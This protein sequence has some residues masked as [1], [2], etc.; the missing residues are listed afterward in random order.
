M[1][2]KGVEAVFIL[3]TAGADGVERTAHV[4][5]VAGAHQVQRTQRNLLAADPQGAEA[6]GG[7]QF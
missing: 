5:A 6:V 2:D 1:A 4:G 7:G 3:G